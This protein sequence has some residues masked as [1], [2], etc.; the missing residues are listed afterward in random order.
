MQALFIFRFLPTKPFR[1]K[2]SFI[3]P[4]PFLLLIIF[5]FQSC[6]VQKTVQIEEQV[7]NLDTILIRP[8]PEMEIYRGSETRINDL[9]HT[10]LEVSFDWDSTYLYGKA[11]LKFRPYFYPTDSLILDAKGFQIKEVALLDSIGKKKALNYDYDSLKL[12]IDLD[13]TYR[14]QDT[15]SI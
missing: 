7:V 3:S 6:N 8:N 14:R 9:L 15:Y 13:S 4:A 11:Y 2:L 1:M 12:Y 5:V 10:K